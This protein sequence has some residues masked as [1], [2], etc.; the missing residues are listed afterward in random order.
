MGL[1]HIQ[2]LAP[3]LVLVAVVGLRAESSDRPS[4][5]AGA[6]TSVADDLAKQ[7]FQI[8]KTN[9]FECHGEPKRGGLDMRTPEALEAGGAKGRSSFRTIPR[10]AG[11]IT[12]LSRARGQDAAA[13]DAKIAEADLETLRTWIEAGGSL[14][15]VKEA[16]GRAAGAGE[17]PEE[18]PIKPQEREYW[19]F[20]A[21][22][23]VVPR[24]RRRPAG[25]PIRSTRSSRRR[26]KPKALKPSAPADRRTLIRRVYLDVLGL[27]P[28][29]E[30][31]R[32]VRR[33]QVAGRVGE[34]RRRA[35][36]VAALRRALGAALDGPRALRGLRRLR[37]RRRS[38]RRLYRYRDYLV[39]A[40]NKD[41]PY[42]Q[43]VKEQLAGDEYTPV[44]DEAMIAT[45][46]LRLG[47][48]GGGT[49]QDALDDLVAH[50]VADVHRADRRLRALPQ[51]QVRSDSAE[52]LLPD[53]VG[54]LRRRRKSSHPLA[55]ARRGR[56]E[57]QGDAAHRRP[58][59][60]AA[61]GEDEDRSAVPADDRR[62]RDREAAGVHAAR[63][64]DAAGRAHARAEA[65]RHADREDACTTRHA[66]ASSS[67]RS[68]IVA[69]MP[70]D[71][72]A[73]HDDVEGADRGARQAEAAAVA[74][75]AGDR[76][77]RPRAAAVVL[78]ASRQPGLAG[79]ADDA[80]RALGR[81]RDGVDVPGAAAPTRSRAGAG[82]AS[83]SGWCR[84]TTRSPRA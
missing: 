81:E 37:V 6:L 8:L 35:A 23:R 58:A 33:R 79:I 11:C 3:W 60:A 77:A 26:W 47:P 40:F 24:R 75:G 65:E 53:S 63:V 84:R 36:R 21:P 46:F 54:L 27:P 80:R 76:R 43:F 55:P 16:G 51:P 74:D 49:R 2:R 44:T 52:G 67:P 59:A 4:A 72:K 83:P 12:T 82:A 41:K 19:A 10:R 39:D 31:G 42:D 66:R 9:C 70:A 29:P 32:R 50:D 73:K 68:D 15:G 1:R 17:K 45:G 48:S 25:T 34:G 38:R 62:S 30:A 7:A 78:P 61:R 69:L 64:E 14:E 5:S 57:P 13:P 18:R 22:V 56:R 28:T 20:K 71:V